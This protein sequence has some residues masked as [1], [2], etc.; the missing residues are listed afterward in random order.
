MPVLDGVSYEIAQPCLDTAAQMKV[1]GIENLGIVGD[2]SHQAG[3]GDHVPWDCTGHPGWITAIDIGWGGTINGTRITPALLRLYLL[4]RL[5]A[6]TWEFYVVKYIITNYLLNDTRWPYNLKDQT[7]GDG[8]DHMHISW[9]NSAI[10]KRVTLIQDFI[11]WVKAGMPNP[12]T[13][14]PRAN[15]DTGDGKMDS[16]VLDDGRDVLGFIDVQGNLVLSYDRGQHYVK[17][18]TSGAYAAGLSLANWKGGA[19]AAARRKSDRGVMLLH[20]PQI[21]AAQPTVGFASQFMNGTSAGPVSL[22]VLPN[23]ELQFYGKST[24]ASQLGVPYGLIVKSDGSSA[25]WQKLEGL[26]A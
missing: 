22:T 4:P 8:P 13:F 1:A 16:I 24:L 14:N 18:S 9:L 7:G 6:H 20:I 23:D 10:H 2:V 12:V 19:L 3:C 21:G 5:R 17:L 25:G 11:A 26:A 15:A